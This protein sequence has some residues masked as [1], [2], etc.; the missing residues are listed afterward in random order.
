MENESDRTV[1][2]TYRQGLWVLIAVI[3]V[4]MRLAQLGS[5][6]LTG[7]EAREAMLAWRA[8]RGEGMPLG[9]YNPMLFAANSLLFTLLGGS[10]ELARLLPALFGAALVLMPFLFER[11]LGRVGA[12]VC[13]LYLA[14]SPTALVGSR[15]LDGTVV[16]AVGALTFL[17]SLLRFAD[18][19]RRGWI[20]S[21]AVGLGVG[22][23]SG[24]AV[25]GLLLPLGLAYAILSTLPLGDHQLDVA[26]GLRRIWGEAALFF[27]VFGI[28]ALLLSTGLGWNL[29]GL[30]ASGGLLAAW[31][32]RFAPAARVPAAPLTLLAVYEL[33]ALVFGLGGLIW[34]AQR[35]R[36]A[37]VLLGLWAGLA[38]LILTLMPG[39]RPTDTLWAVVPLAM[40]VGLV[41]ETLAVDRWRVGRALRVV[42]LAIV[43]VLWAYAYLMLARYGYYGELPDLAL[44]VVAVVLQ[45]LVGLSFELVLGGG[46]S[47]RTAALGTAVVLLGLTAAAA[48]GAAY[49]HPADPREALVSEP[50]PVNVRDLVETLKEISWNET[51]VSTTLAF[52]YEAA[53]DSVLAWYLRDFQMAERVDRLQDLAADELGPILVTEG[54]DETAVPG[55][56]GGYAGQDFPMR[57]QWTPRQ[58]DCRLGEVGCSGPLAWFL[59]R[60]KVPL[61]EP[62]R[63]ATVWRRGTASHSR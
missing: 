43:L 25:Y 16:A 61:P 50:T 38:I 52:A 36:P 13:G 30:G 12:L 10:D 26:A 18:T 33:G 17:G 7:A 58:M 28:T 15:Q 41:A 60:E 37:A 47:L 11:Y 53:P 31:F 40:L 19:D 57:R 42:H 59:F 23:S 22:V 27:S 29:S 46:A 20:I 4:V 51:G 3:A 49:G 39:R 35:G 55:V 62:D 2:L 63:W 8:S 14:I 45:G 56:E 54:R 34:G 5:A 32:E 21:A 44:V 48:W 6:P 24:A 9:P 1:R